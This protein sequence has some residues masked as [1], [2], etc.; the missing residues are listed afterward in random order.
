[1][2]KAAT[3]PTPHCTFKYKPP[4]PRSLD[5][6]LWTCL[7]K[8][9]DQRGVLDTRQNPQVL[10]GPGSASVRADPASSSSPGRLLHLQAICFCARPSA[11]SPGHLLPGIR[12]S[13]LFSCLT[14]PQ[15]TLTN[16]TNGD[17][18]GMTQ[19]IFFQNNGRI[20]KTRRT[21]GRFDSNRRNGRDMGTLVIFYG[22]GSAV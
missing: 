5:P 15:R 10:A 22:N 16:A 9:C 17:V 8:P 2:T 3:N 7:T 11:S 13:S 1:V 21:D 14:G 18:T 4:V 6:A 19:M 12:F 20:R